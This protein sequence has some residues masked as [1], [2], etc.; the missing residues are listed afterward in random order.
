M[1]FFERVL[2]AQI[3]LRCFEWKEQNSQKILAF[4]K[5]SLAEKK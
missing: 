1:Y 2:C 5:Q 4:I 3:F